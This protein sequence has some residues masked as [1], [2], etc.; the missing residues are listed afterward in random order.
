MPV[1]H[2]FRATTLF[3]PKLYHIEG[4]ERTR[5][6]IM[7]IIYLGND[8]RIL[9]YWADCIFLTYAVTSSHSRIPI[10]RIK[11][12]INKHA[13]NM[14]LV[15][16]ETDTFTKHF[17]RIHSGFFLPRWLNLTLDVDNS[18]KRRQIDIAK[19]NTIANNLTMRYADTIPELE[20]FYERMYKPH[21]LNRHKEASVIADL[22]YFKHLFH[23]KGSHLYFILKD[24]EPVGGSFDIAVGKT[25][26]SHSVGVLDGRYDLLQLGVIGADIY[27]KLVEC[28]SKGIKTIDYGGTPPILTSGLT[29]RKIS[30]GGIVMKKK[31]FYEKYVMLIPWGNTMNIKNFLLKNPFIYWDNNEYVR[32]L[33]T[34]S[35]KDI[36]GSQLKAL[37]KQTKFHNNVKTKVYC[38]NSASTTADNFNTDLGSK[39]S[40]DFIDYKIVDNVAR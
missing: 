15:I 20:F 14:D 11:N 23:K 36:D 8:E 32:A 19:K 40:I 16:F 13:V 37:C 28:Q 1:I 17:I 3:F 35:D 6:E 34:E 10:W 25:I 9:S 33:F 39:N 31:R 12:Q 27:L 26:K 21:I 18:L 5:N 29:L 2:F 4:E 22:K 30:I 24:G 7:R 38:F